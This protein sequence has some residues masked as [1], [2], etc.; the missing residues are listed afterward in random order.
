MTKFQKAAQSLLHGNVP[1]TT[2][3]LKN[4]AGKMETYFTLTE[5]SD[6]NISQPISEFHLYVFV[7]LKYKNNNNYVKYQVIYK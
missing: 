5:L 3:T 4:Q 6:L 2:T 1:V 7:I